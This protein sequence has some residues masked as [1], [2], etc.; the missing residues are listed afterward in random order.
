MGDRDHKD[1]AVLRAMLEDN[2]AVNAEAARRI[3]ICEMASRIA[4]GSLARETGK[5]LEQCS[6]DDMIA[7]EAVAIAEAI[8]E[9]AHRP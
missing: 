2:Y 6:S 7:G 9:R 5:D 1:E 4:A 3:L 8:Y